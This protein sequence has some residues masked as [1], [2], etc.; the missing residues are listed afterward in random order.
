MS[1]TVK[2]SQFRSTLCQN[3]WGISMRFDRSWST[4]CSWVELQI[5]KVSFFYNWKSFNVSALRFAH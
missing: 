3:I 2:T 1:S 4:S 5:S